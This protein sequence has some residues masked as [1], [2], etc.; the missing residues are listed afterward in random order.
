MG[1]RLSR[2]QLRQKFFEFD[3]NGDGKL[4]V[5]ELRQ[6]LSELLRC[7]VSQQAAQAVFD[8]LNK[9]QDGFI[10]VDEWLDSLDRKPLKE[11][12]KEDIEKAFKAADTS[13]DG[14]ISKAELK[15]ILKGKNCQV[16]DADLD[17]MIKIA[18][19]D[20]D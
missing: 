7:E 13:G 17:A 20:N 3:K 16:S 19:K 18:D 6:H 8:T 2:E 4:N 11:F 12:G 10:T 15:A 9:D 5:V 14:K 1:P